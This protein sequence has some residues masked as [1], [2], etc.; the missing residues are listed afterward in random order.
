M[1]RDEVIAQTFAAIDHHVRCASI[2]VIGGFR[3]PAEAVTSFFGGR[4]VGN[5]GEPW[6]ATDGKPMIPLLQIRSDELAYRPAALK[7][8]EL[9]NVFIGPDKLPTDLPAENGDGW[10]VR[11]YSKLENLE[12][13]ATPAEIAVRPFP[14]RWQLSSSE[15]P[16]WDDAWELHDL[17]EFN[18]LEDAIELFYDRYQAQSRTKVGGW[19]SYTQGSPG[20]DGFVFQ[21]G[22]EE[23]P[24]WMWGDNGSGYFYFRN[25]K[26]FLHWDCY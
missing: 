12:P 2:A 1:L 5:P 19:P 18:K 13:L 6:P 25:G 15:A 8:W 23:K 7:E 16:I 14:I 17:S 3:P 24:Q 26:W 20:S 4:F 10:L 9:L 11:S 21:I 22:S